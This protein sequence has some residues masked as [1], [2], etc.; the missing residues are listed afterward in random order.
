MGQILAGDA[1]SSAAPLCVCICSCFCPDKMKVVFYL[2]PVY[3]HIIWCLRCL[4]VLISLLA[5]VMRQQEAH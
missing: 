4:Q 3:F 1:G 5:H 2:K